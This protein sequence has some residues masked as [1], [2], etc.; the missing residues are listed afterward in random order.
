MGKQKPD[1]NIQPPNF[2]Y[3][4]EGFAPKKDKKVVY[5]E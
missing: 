1:P 4:T 3:V 2:E 5:N